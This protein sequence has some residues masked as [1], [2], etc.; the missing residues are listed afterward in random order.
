MI[1]AVTEDDLEDYLALRRESLKES[2]LAFGASPADDFAGS[3][4][5]VRGALRRAPDWMLFGAF[6]PQ[7]VGAVGLL[8][9]DRAK[10]MHKASLWGLFVTPSHRRRGFGAALLEAAI[11]HAR[12]LPGLSMVQ[13]TVTE[14]SPEARKLY[15][16]AGFVLWGTEPDAFRHEGTSVADHHMALRLD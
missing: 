13:L 14:A 6:D 15:E 11:L 7:L 9:G 4:S 5:A 3:A 10:S 1:R 8:R 2:P 16:T 12:T